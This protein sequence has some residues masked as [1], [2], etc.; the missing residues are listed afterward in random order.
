MR[1][2]AT[3]FFCIIMVL[4]LL[5][6]IASAKEFRGIVQAMPE[7]GYIGQWKIDDKIVN[8]TEETKI[9][10]EHGK[11]SV[12]SHVKVEGLTCEGKFVASEIEV[13]EHK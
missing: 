13:K 4:S 7:K 11:P 3:T 6:G 12:G 5:A 9:E 2:K 8:V 10:E 1:K